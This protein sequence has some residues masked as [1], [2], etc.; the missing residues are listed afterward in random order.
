M[1]STGQKCKK[2]DKNR[3]THFGGKWVDSEQADMGYIKYKAEKSTFALFKHKALII[4]K[5]IKGNYRATTGQF[6]KNRAKFA[7]FCPALSVRAAMRR[8]GVIPTR[9]CPRRWWV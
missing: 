3:D 7:L 9:P 5:T 4:K 8:A 1:L 6:K 2:I